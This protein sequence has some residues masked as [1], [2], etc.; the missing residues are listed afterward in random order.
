MIQSCEYAK[1]NHNCKVFNTNELDQYLVVKLSYNMHNY[2]L[3]DILDIS[4]AEAK[5][6]SLSG[7]IFD[8]NNPW[9][10]IPWKNLDR[11][12]G[13]HVYKLSFMGKKPPKYLN[14]YISYILQD[15][16]PYKPYLY[17]NDRYN[18]QEEEKQAIY[19]GWY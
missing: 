4:S 2:R 16:S 7:V 15:D 1:L 9:I 8:H 13:K 17:M 10:D 14:T 11:T 18:E 5:T 19:L 3:Y 12:S 6:V